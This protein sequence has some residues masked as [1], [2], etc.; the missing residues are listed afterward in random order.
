MHA[1]RHLLTTRGAAFLSAGTVL[2][3]C[4]ILL[5]Q[6]DLTRVG[7]LLFVLLIAAALMGRR[8]GLHLDVQRTASPSRVCVD[9]PAVVTM[10][11]QNLEGTRSPV[12]LAEEQLDY[13]LGDRP[14]FVIPAMDAQQR[15]TMQYAVRAHSRGL[16]RLGPLGIRIRDPFGLTTRAATVGAA[17][18]ILVLPHVHE[19]GSHRP[20]GRGAGSEGSIPHR[21]ALHGEDDQAV[22]EYRDGDDLRRIHW[23]AT[24]RTGDLMVRQEDRPARRT[25]VIL[26]DSRAEAHGGSGRNSSLEWAISLCASAAAHLEGQGYLLRVLT[27]DADHPTGVREDDTLDGALDALARLG[28]G[29]SPGFDAVLHAAGADGVQGAALLAVT[30]ALD[31][32]AAHALASLRQPGSPGLALVVDRAAFSRS[33]PLDANATGAADAT[34]AALSAAGWSAAAV[35][36]SLSPADAWSIVT[37]SQSALAGAP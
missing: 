8:H 31:D 14:R 1:L 6:R 23:P 32:R 18:T 34:I 9:E 13:A 22:R 24:A 11:V 36:P 30:G 17:D 16:H 15:R 5:G 10:S 29:A 37:G 4:G 27:T 7:V 25:A 2:V 20:I 19:L 28:P 33:R 35:T 21:I 12:A 3:V 26:L